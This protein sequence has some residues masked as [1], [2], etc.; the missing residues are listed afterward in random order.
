MEASGIDV[1]AASQ[2]PDGS[3]RKERK[4][5]VGYVPQDEVEKYESRTKKFF[6]EKPEYPP[7]YNPNASGVEK[8]LSKNQ[9]KNERKKQKRQVQLNG[10]NSSTLPPTT[11]VTEAV[12]KLS[13]EKVSCNKASTAKAF[14]QADLLKKIKALKKKLKQIDQLEEKLS[15]GEALEDLQIEKISKKTKLEQE[16]KQL[17]S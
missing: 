6:S 4:V 2:R 10:E 15:K 11:E 12:N 14:D 9:K 16:L 1:I 8:P 7:G 3:W 13:I 5:K 17:Q